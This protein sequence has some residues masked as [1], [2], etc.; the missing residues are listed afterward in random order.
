M[1]S[2][3]SDLDVLRKKYPRFY[4]YARAKKL[5]KKNY[6][7]NKKKYIEYSIKY[8]KKI[9]NCKFCRK[10]FTYGNIKYHVKSESHKKSIRESENIE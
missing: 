9:Y 10:S 1:S 5:Y 3:E 2:I 6:E 7:N 4:I 8:N